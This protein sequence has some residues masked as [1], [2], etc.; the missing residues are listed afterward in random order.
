MCCA[1]LSLMVRLLA[2]IAGGHSP[3]P[4][5]SP[6][7]N[8]PVQSQCCSCTGPCGSYYDCKRHLSSNSQ[9][10]LKQQSRFYR[11]QGHGQCMARLGSYNEVVER[12]RERKHGLEV[13]LLLGLKMGLV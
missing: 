1:G 12:E 9:G 10:I 13:L 3:G 6:H 5:A 4:G 8:V 7:R 11:T 2:R